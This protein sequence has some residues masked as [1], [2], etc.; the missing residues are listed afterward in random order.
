MNMKICLT[1]IVAITCWSSAAIAENLDINFSELV[2][3][4]ALL[5]NFNSFETTAFIFPEDLES[6]DEMR[7]VISGSSC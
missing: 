3:D 1:I 4:Y 6:F 5:P 2:G 7:L